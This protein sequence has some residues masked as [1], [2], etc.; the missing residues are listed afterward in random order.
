[1]EDS[2]RR[3]TL[4]IALIDLAQLDVSGID[5]EAYQANRMLADATA[6]RVMHVGENAI[7]LDPVIRARYPYLPWRDMAAMRN[8]VAHDY[9]RISDGLIWLTVVEY[10]DELRIACAAELAALE[11]QGE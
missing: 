9:R 2:T 10:L 4:I 1:M 7:R 5:E 6:H 3:L 11:D 8:V